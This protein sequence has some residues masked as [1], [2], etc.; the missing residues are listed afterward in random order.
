MARTFD[1]PTYRLTKRADQVYQAT[2]ELGLHPRTGKRTT[3]ARTFRGTL[4]SCERA[5]AAWFVELCR[6]PESDLV[7]RTEQ[8][9]SLFLTSWLET[10]RGTIKET[11]WHRY[12]S[13]L[14]TSVIPALGH[15]RLCDLSPQHIR[16]YPPGRVSRRA[17]QAPLR[18]DEGT[19]RPRER[20]CVGQ[21]SAE[22]SRRPFSGV[23]PSSP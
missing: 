5:A 22:P 16:D 3:T 7:G 14:K 13:L 9:L 23:A 15:I 17:V 10:K 2:A 8:P 1:G 21:D 6:P 18:A 19:P 11:S 20:A 4:R 12:E